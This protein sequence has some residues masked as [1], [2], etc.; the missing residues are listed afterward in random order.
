MNVLGLAKKEGNRG[1]SGLHSFPASSA[2]KECGIRNASPHG[3]TSREVRHGTV[4]ARGISCVAH[5]QSD[6]T[7]HDV[8]DYAAINQGESNPSVD[9][10]PFMMYVCVV[11]LFVSTFADDTCHCTIMGTDDDDACHLQ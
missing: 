4:A 11:L 8:L 7:R 6:A 3:L 1:V 9:R 2:V 5:H 10:Q